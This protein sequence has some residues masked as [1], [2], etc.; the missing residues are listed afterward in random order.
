MLKESAI[1]KKMQKH[2]LCKTWMTASGLLLCSLPFMALANDIKTVQT[3]NNSLTTDEYRARMDQASTVVTESVQNHNDQVLELNTEK[4]ISDYFDQQLDA[5]NALTPKL[6]AATQTI[7]STDTPAVNSEQPRLNDQTLKL[8]KQ[9]SLDYFSAF[10]S[11]DFTLSDLVVMANQNGYTYDDQARDLNAFQTE[12]KAASDTTD[13]LKISHQLSINKQAFIDTSGNTPV[14]AILDQM[15]DSGVKAGI[16]AAAS[17]AIAAGYWAAAI[18]SFGGTIGSATAATI[19]TVLLTAESAA[20]IAFYTAYKD[21]PEYLNVA[22]LTVINV[23]KGVSWAWTILWLPKTI[24]DFIEITVESI[25]AIRIA[26]IALKAGIGA[27]SWAAPTGLAFLILA[28]VV[29]LITE[30]ILD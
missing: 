23:V 15:H 18:F 17:A 3:S 14:S 10:Q 22:D 1:M 11:G 2:K 5:T 25:K 4:S 6:N 28:D 30:L 21:K 13:S 20:N 16:F 24:T 29:L 19:Q 9:K 8:V 27:T 26:S 7:D 12:A